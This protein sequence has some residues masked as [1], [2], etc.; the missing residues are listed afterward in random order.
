[1]AT[2]STQ[3]QGK[4][5]IPI[6]TVKISIDAIHTVQV[7]QFMIA[8]NIPFWI[9]SFQAEASTPPSP[10]RMPEPQIPAAPEAQIPSNPKIKDNLTMIYEEFILGCPENAPPTEVEIAAKYGMG[11][12]S[13]R[14]RF[15]DRYG[16]PFYQI[17]MERKMAVAAA[18]LREGHKANFVSD[19]L[20][21]SQPIKFNQIFRKYY[22]TTPYKYKKQHQ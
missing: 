18:M 19:K 22:G 9:T 4:K 2:H 8:Q 6:S 5:N 21:Y 10:I 3:S 13:F 20:G 16:K 11:V 7:I 17:L 15:K 14:N 12:S 1:M